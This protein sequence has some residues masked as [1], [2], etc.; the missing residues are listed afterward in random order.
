MRKVGPTAGLLFASASSASQSCQPDPASSLQV[1]HTTLSSPIAFSASQVLSTKSCFQ[2]SGRAATALRAI[3]FSS[4]ARSST[5][6]GRH[7]AKRSHCLFRV[8]SSCLL[9]GEL[10]VEGDHSGCLLEGALLVEGDHPGCLE[11]E[12]LVEGDH[13]GCRPAPPPRRA[14]GKWKPTDLVQNCR[15]TDL[16]KKCR[17]QKRISPQ[18]E[19]GDIKNDSFQSKLSIWVEEGGCRPKTTVS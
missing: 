18:R 8:Y 11:G 10:L 13:S 4:Q 1:G 15:S 5:Y 16:F 3:Y 19:I 9:E 12:L 7:V 14:L 2:F 6:T 17:F